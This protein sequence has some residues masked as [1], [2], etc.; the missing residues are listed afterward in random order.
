MVCHISSHGRWQ[1]AHY[2]LTDLVLAQGESR[3]IRF[4][5]MS[6]SICERRKQ[7]YEI[8]EQTKVL[9]KMLND[10]FQQGINSSQYQKM[11]QVSRATA[12]RHLNHLMELGCL[13]KTDAGGRST[14]YVIHHC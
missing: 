6:V 2:P 8:L 1:W 14:R 5:A 11:A 4:Y 9:N 10:D 13:K 7:Y 12:T 3:S